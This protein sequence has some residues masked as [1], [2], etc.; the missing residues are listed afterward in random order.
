MGQAI[1][2]GPSLVG[3]KI[4]LPL[5]ILALSKTYL[6]RS[7]SQKRILPHDT[8]RCDLVYLGEPTRRFAASEITRAGDGHRGFPMNMPAAPSLGQSIPHTTC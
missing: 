5:D 3:Q 8:S 7:E 2:Y 1:L 4:L 6:P